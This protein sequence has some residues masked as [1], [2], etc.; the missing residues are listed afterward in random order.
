MNV[1]SSFVRAIGFANGMHLFTEQCEALL[2]A[3]GNS[4]ARVKVKNF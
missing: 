2:H 3:T 1:F 4:E